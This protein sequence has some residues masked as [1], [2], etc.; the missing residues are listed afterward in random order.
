MVSIDSFPTQAFGVRDAESSRYVRDRR[1]ARPGCLF[2]LTAQLPNKPIIEELM[3]ARPW[4]RNQSSSSPQS[5]KLLFLI[6]D[7]AIN[8]C[9]FED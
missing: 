9:D 1:F 4:K 2:M 6:A 3:T 7:I 5:N 8:V